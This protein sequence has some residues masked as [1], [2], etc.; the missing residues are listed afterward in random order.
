M[1]EWAAAGEFVKRAYLIVRVHR[2]RDDVGVFLV[3]LVAV[4]VLAGHTLV[5]G[6]GR[7]HAH[8]GVMMVI[9][10][11]AATAARKA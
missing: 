8:S 10:A 3:A 5:T 7:R 9:F 4:V 1:H 11:S 2:L 6:T